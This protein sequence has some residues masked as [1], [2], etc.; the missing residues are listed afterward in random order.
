[1]T[2]E[3]AEVSFGFFFHENHQR[4]KG[5]LLYRLTDLVAIC[6]TRL[7]LYHKA[8][9]RLKVEYY[10]HTLDCA[11]GLTVV[12]GLLIRHSTTLSPARVLILREICK[13]SSHI[14]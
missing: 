11:V 9:R 1:L 3:V 6:S 12:V 8:I 5:G 10:R 7:L 4:V 13:I 14:S 2:I